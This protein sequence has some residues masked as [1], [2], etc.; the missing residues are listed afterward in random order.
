MNSEIQKT[1]S[2]S[3]Y[4]KNLDLNRQWSVEVQCSPIWKG[5]WE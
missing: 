1:V 2:F 4:I 5:E 3:S